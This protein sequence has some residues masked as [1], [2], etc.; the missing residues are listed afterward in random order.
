MPSTTFR[1]REY[2]STVAGLGVIGAGCAGDAPDGT[3]TRE[4][5]STPQ[6]P[7]QETS[8]PQGPDHDDV[9]ERV[10]EDPPGSPA[11]DPAGSWPSARYDAGNTGYNSAGIGVRDGEPYWRLAA[12]GPATIDDDTLYNVTGRDRDERALTFRDPT[13]A[14]ID[15]ER[16]LVPYAVSSPPVVADDGVFVTTFIEVF[17]FD[18]ED[19]DRLWRGP[20]MDGIQAP[21]T[22]HD[23]TVYV[24]S[25]GFQAV[26]PHLRAFDPDGEEL[27]RY[28]T[29]YE[30]KGKPAVE[31]DHVFVSTEEGLHAVDVATGEA[32][33][34]L[35]IGGSAWETPVVRDGVVYTYGT[36]D[37]SPSLIAVD[38]GGGT[39]R[40]HMET[41]H[42]EAPVVSEEFVYA[43]RDDELIAVA[44]EDGSPERGFD[45]VARPM[46][47]V[48]DVLYAEHRGT[49]LA[50]DATTGERLWRLRTEEVT[51]AD[52]V[53]R[54][55]GHVAPVDGAV[56]VSARDAFYGVGP[57]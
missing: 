35:P 1:R 31:G 12:G 30:S 50:F 7:D 18:G 29:E 49:A 23:G 9:D 16:P 37:G 25:G 51:I 39:V 47:R 57:S 34:V 17:C 26:D 19:G 21:P 52:T 43:T 20:E 33:Y 3:P 40:W 27:W 15:R 36:V 53:A 38:A 44:V 48:G 6:G 46:A 56:Y 24:N 54:Y 55:V 11:L 22:V 10:D 5:T 45:E 14:E 42:D 2:L 32:E 13:N 28:D 4:E 41:A 8:T